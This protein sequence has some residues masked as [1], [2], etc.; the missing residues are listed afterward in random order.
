[1]E[2]VEVMHDFEARNHVLTGTE[3]LAKS[4]KQDQMRRVMVAWLWEVLMKLQQ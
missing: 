2:Q 3:K 4:A 1:V